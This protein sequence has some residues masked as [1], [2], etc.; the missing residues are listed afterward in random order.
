MEQTTGKCS[1]LFHSAYDQYLPCVNTYPLMWKSSF[2]GLIRMIISADERSSNQKKAEEKEKETEK[3]DNG[4]HGKC[5][6]YSVQ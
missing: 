4:K 2:I 3:Y 6:K 1:R 5:I